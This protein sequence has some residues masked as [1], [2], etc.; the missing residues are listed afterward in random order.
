[1]IFC[2]SFIFSSHCL[3]HSP[4]TLIFDLSLEESSELEA[5]DEFVDDGGNALLRHRREGRSGLSMR[6]LENDPQAGAVGFVV[7]GADGAG[8]LGEF[9][10]ERR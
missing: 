5:S 10:R 1:V 3:R 2:A 8:K 6:I 9:E 7:A 4:E